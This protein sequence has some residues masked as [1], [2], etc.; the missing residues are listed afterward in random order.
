MKDWGDRDHEVVELLVSV[1]AG[2]VTVR[3]IEYGLR[4]AKVQWSSG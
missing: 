1:R 4:S 3:Q 2:A